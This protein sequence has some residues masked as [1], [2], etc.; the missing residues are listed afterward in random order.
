MVSVSLVGVVSGCFRKPVVLRTSGRGENLEQDQ[1]DPSADGCL[2][3]EARERREPNLHL[4][5]RTATFQVA[6]DDP[7]WQPSYFCLMCVKTRSGAGVVAPLST[8]TMMEKA[9]GCL[10]LL[11]RPALIF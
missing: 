11:G 5:P 10:T 3:I 4:C 9:C 8:L 1:A 2:V 6:A 7:S